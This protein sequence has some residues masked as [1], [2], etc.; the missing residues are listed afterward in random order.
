VGLGWPASVSQGL[1]LKE[2]C[3]GAGAMAQQLKALAALPEG[4]KFNNF[5]QPHGGA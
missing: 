5:Q 1:R 2:S 4:P 3:A